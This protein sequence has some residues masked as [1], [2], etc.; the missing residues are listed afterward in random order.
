VWDNVGCAG[1]LEVG[2]EKEGC[3][4]WEVFVGGRICGDGEG[5]VAVS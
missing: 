3:I 1:E 2:V 5:W 4:G